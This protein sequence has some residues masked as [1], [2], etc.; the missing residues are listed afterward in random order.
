MTS[1]RHALPQEWQQA[2]TYVLQIVAEFLLPCLSEPSTVYYRH[3]LLTKDG[4]G[5]WS[6]RTSKTL[7]HCLSKIVSKGRRR[8]KDTTL[9]RSWAR[10]AQDIT[11]RNFANG[12]RGPSETVRHE[13]LQIVRVLQGSNTVIFT[14]RERGRSRRSCASKGFDTKTGRMS[15]LQW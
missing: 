8:H 14:V 3:S 1:D 9:K 5:L 10:V 6:E 2:C 13:T 12:Q 7:R 15:D 11:T 4:H